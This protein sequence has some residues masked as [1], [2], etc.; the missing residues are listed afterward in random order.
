MGTRNLLLGAVVS[1]D[2]DLIAPHIEDVEL[3]YRQVV[4]RCRRRPEF[5]YFPEQ[6][7]VSIYALSTYRDQ[8]DVGTIGH[9]GCTAIEMFLGCQRARYD[10]IVIIPGRGKRVR[11]DVLVDLAQRTPSLRDVFL[12]Y[13]YCSLAQARETALANAQGTIVERLARWVLVASDSLGGRVVRVTHEDPSVCL[14]VRRA[15]VTVALRNLANAGMIDLARGRI[16][17]LDEVA[18]NKAASGFFTRAVGPDDG[19]L[20]PPEGRGGREATNLERCRPV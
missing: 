13:A 12:R 5:V 10:A 14:G 1:G 8:A 20:F 2:L 19:H 4:M 18:L 15:G 6:G 3:C 11:T 9:E 7:L 16:E 17:V